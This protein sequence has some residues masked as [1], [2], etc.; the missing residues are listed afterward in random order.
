M[1]DVSEK[2]EYHLTP[3]TTLRKYIGL[4]A[5]IHIYPDPCPAPTYTQCLSQSLLVHTQREKQ[6]D[7]HR[8]RGRKQER[9][10]QREKGREKEG[11]FVE[12]KILQEW[13][14]DIKLKGAL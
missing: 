10:S 11:R 2:T 5:C 8:K 1:P 4:P 13:K 14:G 6:K 7:T 12:E 9:E 3:W